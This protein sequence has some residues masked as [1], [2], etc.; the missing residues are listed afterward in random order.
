MIHKTSGHQRATALISLMG[1]IFL[2]PLS[3][4]AAVLKAGAARVDITPPAGIRMWGYSNSSVATG[5]LDPLYARVLVLEVGENRL[6]WVDLDLG[7]VFGEQSLE[8][9]RREAQRCCGINSVIV[10]AI[11]THAGPEVRDE[12]PSGQTPAWEATALTRIGQAIRQAWEQAAP[13]RLGVGYGQA[14]IGYNRRRPNTDGSVTMIW[15]N[16][17]QAP[18]APVDPTLAVLRIDR[19]DGTPLAIL[20][21]YACHPVTFGP[22]N[23][24]FSAD[25]PGVMCKLVR[26]AFPGHPIC[27]Y[28]Q[29]AAGDINVYNASTAVKDGAAELRIRAG[30]SLGRE[31]I[32]V[33]K[34]IQTKADPQP[35]LQ[36]AEDDLP[37]RLRW[38]PT[39]FRQAMLK[40]GAEYVPPIEPL[41]HVPVTTVLIDKQIAMLGMPGEPFVEFQ[42]AWRA[43][44]PVQACLF[45]GYTNGYFGYIPTIRAAAQGGYGAANEQT[46][47]QVGAGEAMLDHALVTVYR[48]LGRLHDA[49]QDNWI[50]VP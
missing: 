30:E 7:R 34:A 8:G 49:P 12:Y 46:R 25:F 38:N 5:A 15:N 32:Q 18:T 29:G 31:V 10:Q 22:D 13:V 4:P 27:F 23:T 45:L 35:S 28:I 39:K 40:F 44:C 19:I 26:A 17:A 2:L 3:G 6:A 20:A 36:F 14:Y 48:M 21:N 11:H 37:F 42:M 33:A 50:S 24:Q 41:M 9:L 1:S 47:L 43:R 16:A